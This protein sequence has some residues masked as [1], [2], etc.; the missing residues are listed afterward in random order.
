MM[1]RE[2]HIPCWWRPCRW[3]SVSEK[4]GWCCDWLQ[5]H[6]TNRQEITQARMSELGQGDGSRTRRTVQARGVPTP[7]ETQASRSLLVLPHLDPRDATQACWPCRGSESALESDF[8]PA[9]TRRKPASPFVL[10]W[11]LLSS[12]PS[13]ACPSAAKRSLRVSTYLR[14]EK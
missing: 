2:P 9:V 3:S 5:R 8:L 12:A 10:S 14:T 1:A 4:A 11:P 13:I 7:A 6:R